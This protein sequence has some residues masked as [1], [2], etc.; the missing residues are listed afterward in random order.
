MHIVC[1]GF[2]KQTKKK[3][4]FGFMRVLHEIIAAFVK[5]KL[6]VIMCSLCLLLVKE[7]WLITALKVP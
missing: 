1:V 3:T 4:K 2:L 7:V 5:L 6:F